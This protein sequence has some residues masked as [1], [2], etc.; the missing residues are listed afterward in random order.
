MIALFDEGPSREKVVEQLKKL[1]AEFLAKIANGENPEQV[2]ELMGERVF[3]NG[4]K[5]LGATA[6]TLRSTAIAGSVAATSGT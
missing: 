6:I 4:V 1:R 2:A 3:K 5:G